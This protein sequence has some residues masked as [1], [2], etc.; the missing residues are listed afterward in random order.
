MYNAY[1]PMDYYMEITNI[2]KE[3]DLVPSWL[4]M[5]YAATQL[6]LKLTG[7]LYEAGIAWGLFSVVSIYGQKKSKVVMLWIK[8]DS[9]R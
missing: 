8:T 5:Y 9:T 4:F 7:L 6:E 1:A 3:L 2:W